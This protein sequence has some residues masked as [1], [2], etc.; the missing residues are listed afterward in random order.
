MVDLSWVTPEIAVGGCFARAD[1]AALAREHQIRGV[2]DLRAEACDPELELDSHGIQ[3]L[4][5]PTFDHAAVS[6][7]MLRAGV[8]FAR[9][10]LDAGD[11]VLLHCQHGIGRSGLLAL[12]VLV[13]RGYSPIL[14]LELAKQN[15][16]K[17]SPS[18]QQYEAWV[19]WLT[20]RGIE[21]PDF[22]AFA[23]IAYRHLRT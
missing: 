3:L 5:L 23:Q 6:R 4:H 19:G 18:P 7:P 2:V 21:A 15:R 1:I 16:P 17:V 22:L 14:A 10:H 13:D 11:R 12:C 8:S 9:R 20:E